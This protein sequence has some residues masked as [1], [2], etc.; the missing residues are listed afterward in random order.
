[1]FSKPL[2]LYV[3]TTTWFAMGRPR[4]AGHLAGEHE[5]LSQAD[6]TAV[7]TSLREK[8]KHR[9]VKLILSARQC[10]FAVLPWVS[11]CFT[12]RAIR[13]YVESS[14]EAEHGVTTATHHIE[15]DWPRYARPIVATAYPR[16]LVEALTAALGSAGLELVSA[17]ASV[18]PVTSSYRSV[19]DMAHGLLAYAEDDGL[20]AVSMEQGEIAAVEVLHGGACALNELEVWVSR[21]RFGF[22]RDEQ[23]RWLGT[24]AKP[25]VFPGVTLPLADAELPMSA[26]HGVVSACL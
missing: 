8:F 26:G 25:D 17:G 22:P 24:A 7:A 3:S 4:T 5:S 9:K 23:M 21:K 15:I 14:F 2:L 1:M 16:L 6:W 12:A 13:R 19:P 20:T 11:S 18:G 10:R